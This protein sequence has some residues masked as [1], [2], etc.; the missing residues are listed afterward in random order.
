MEKS[1][2]GGLVQFHMIIL[3]ILLDNCL[4]ITVLTLLVSARIHSLSKN[5]SSSFSR[6]VLFSFLFFFCVITYK[7]VSLTL[8]HCSFEILHARWAMLAA[9]GALIPEILDLLGAFHF[10]EPVWWRVGYSKLK[11]AFS[12]TFS[13][14]LCSRF[15]FDKYQ[16]PQ[17]CNFCTI[18]FVML[19]YGDIFYNS[20]KWRVIC[21]L[22]ELDL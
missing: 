12:S 8:L 5:I 19:C 9:L 15:R 18:W 1:V 11:V 6:L 16:V 2:L 7:L 17:D 22:L 21:T 3:P 20:D 4:G 10:A 13:F 14:A